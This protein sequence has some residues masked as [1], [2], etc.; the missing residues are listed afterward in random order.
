MSIKISRFEAENFKRLR[1]VELTPDGTMQVIGGRNAQG[2]TSVLDAWVMALQY[3]TGKKVN[4]KPVRDGEERATVKLELS[5]GEVVKFNLT[6][7]FTP[8]GKHDIKLESPEGARFSSPQKMLD[9]I[10]G[11]L[12]FDP[13]AFA[14][15]PDKE[16]LATLLS[17]VELGDFNVDANAGKRQSAYEARTEVNRRVKDLEGQ[18]KVL[19]VPP[20]DLPEQEIS[21]GEVL[22][23]LQA[24]Q[25]LNRARHDALNGVAV[26]DATV[27]RLRAE[28]MD[29][30]A[31]QSA[32]HALLDTLP[33]AVDEAQ[34]STQLAGLEQTNARIREGIDRA[35]KVR[36]LEAVQAESAA[37]TA[38]IEALDQEKSDALAAAKLPLD[39]LGF[40]DEGV[41]YQGQPFSQASGA[42]QLR[43]SLAIA[44][45]LNPTLRVIRVADASL[46]DQDNLKLV[47]AMAAEN[48]FQ[49]W[50]EVVGDAAGV[51][52]VIEDGQVAS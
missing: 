20:A 42:E 19:Q 10:V 37:L 5:E 31:H 23:Q 48:D 41:T 27:E 29:A 6:H 11:R 36:N 15:A 12:S 32:A 52:V 4:F 2:K 18:I 14:N 24:A 1:H 46:L 35:T 13:L 45:A 39:G 30:I 26:A 28:L 3:A 22:A 16:Q 21:S 50:L 38:Q 49:I 25:E 44:M 51:G 33:S 8:D 34:F 9:E 7:S 43:V 40:T 17:V 47:E